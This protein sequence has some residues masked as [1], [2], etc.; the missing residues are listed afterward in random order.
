MSISNFESIF[1]KNVMSVSNFFFCKWMSDYSSTSFRK[2]LSFYIDIP[3]LP[4]PR[5]L[6][7]ICI[8]LFLH[9]LFYSINVCIYP[10]T[11]IFLLIV[12]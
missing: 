12:T 4:C 2:D 3:L 6:D 1:V 5:L 9:F 10:L 8:G 11:K 7:Y